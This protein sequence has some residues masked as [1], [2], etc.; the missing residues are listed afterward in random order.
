MHAPADRVGRHVQMR[1]W[2]RGRVP[3]PA[4]QFAATLIKEVVDVPHRA[5]MPIVAAILHDLV[6]MAYEELDL[7]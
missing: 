7:A 2:A 4:D 3:V 6:L 5:D 1:V